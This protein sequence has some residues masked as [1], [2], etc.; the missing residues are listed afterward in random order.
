MGKY[1]SRQMEDG[2]REYII[3]CPLCGKRLDQHDLDEIFTH[4]CMA[5]GAVVTNHHALPSDPLPADKGPNVFEGQPWDKCDLVDIRVAIERGA[6]IK[7]IAL[8]MFR[9]V[10]EMQAKVAELGLVVKPEALLN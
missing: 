6:T 8:V 10:E 5:P 7:E 3:E 2:S 9:G 1:V 4:V